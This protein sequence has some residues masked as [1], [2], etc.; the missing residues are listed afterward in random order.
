LTTDT[1]A[2][3]K[4]CIKCEV[5]KDLD[6]YPLDGSKSD[7][8]KGT[9]KECWRAHQRAYV[10]LKGSQYRYDKMRKWRLKL[11]QRA[12]NALGGKCVCCG[13]TELLFLTL[14]HVNEDG[15]THRKSDDRARSTKL[16]QQMLS[17]ECNYEMQ[18]LCANCHLAKNGPGKCRVHREQT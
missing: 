2:H 4:T 17:G 12:V 13:E 18:V 15:G 11:K 9:C 7:G 5:I 14:D 3:M 16:W 1:L 8:H 10:A 6:E